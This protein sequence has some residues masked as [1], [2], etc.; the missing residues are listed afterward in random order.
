MYR[1]YIH[2]HSRT[3]VWIKRPALLSQWL[4]TW[5]CA[6]WRELSEINVHY[7]SDL[8]PKAPLL[9]FR[10]SHAHAKVY[11][12]EPTRLHQHLV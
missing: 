12:Q 9:T 5:M 11:I 2:F 1:S 7:R 8:I 3:I 6:L 4:Y 10:R